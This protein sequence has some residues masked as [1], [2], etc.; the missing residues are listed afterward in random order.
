MCKNEKK[1]SKEFNEMIF[2]LD[3]KLKEL[4]HYENCSEEQKKLIH[5]DY[6]EFLN[7]I[8]STESFNSKEIS[9]IIFT[10]ICDFLE[11]HLGLNVT[12]Q[13]KDTIFNYS[14]NIENEIT[15][16]VLNDEKRNEFKNKLSLHEFIEKYNKEIDEKIIYYNEIIKECN[17]ID[18]MEDSPL[19]SFRAMQ[20]YNKL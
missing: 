20:I 9:S 13:L 14:L 16:F 18:L 15:E 7:I 5:D 11:R 8:N 3:E 2:E 17:E 4:K 12:N 10:G 1:N 19:K 6:E